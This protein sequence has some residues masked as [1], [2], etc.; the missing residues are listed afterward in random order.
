MTD[1][2]YRDEE[3][4][5]KVVELMKMKFHLMVTWMEKGQEGEKENHSVEEL[6]G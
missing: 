1:Y 5:V 3:E 6:E 4:D 2:D